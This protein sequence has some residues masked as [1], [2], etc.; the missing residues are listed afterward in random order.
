LQP[1][2]EDPMQKYWHPIAY[3]SKSFTDIEVQYD[4][5]E[6]ELAAITECFKVWRH[7]LKDTTHIIRV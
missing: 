3:H 2:T 4:I 7:Y 5:F 1:S 6:K